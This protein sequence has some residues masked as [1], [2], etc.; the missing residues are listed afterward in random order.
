M[1]GEPTAHLVS[2]RFQ[3]CDELMTARQGAAS[4]NL[5]ST[6]RLAVRQEG[7]RSAQTGFAD[8]SDRTASASPRTPQAIR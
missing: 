8:P 5:S 3:L 6:R 2:D 1:T 4:E 7:D